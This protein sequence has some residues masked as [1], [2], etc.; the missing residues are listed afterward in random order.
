M[1]W[2]STRTVVPS[3]AFEAL[4][5]TAAPS[6]LDD[7]VVVAGAAA[8]EEE[9]ELLELLPH[10]AKVSDAASGRARNF[11]AERI[12]DSFWSRQRE[13][14]KAVHR[15]CLTYTTPRC[16]FP[17]ATSPPPEPGHGQDSGLLR[18]C[19]LRVPRNADQ[20]CKA[21]ATRTTTMIT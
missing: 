9:P 5:T 11:K 15:G 21:C 18:S 4:F 7:E 2:A 13:D 20:A 8:C 14:G 6:P 16:S 12:G 1:P 10:A 17:S 3:V 19:S